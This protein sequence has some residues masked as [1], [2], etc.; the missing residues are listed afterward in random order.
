M[1]TKRESKLLEIELITEYLYLEDKQAVKVV[2]AMMLGSPFISDTIKLSLLDAFLHRP[3]IP[4]PVCTE[5]FLTAFF[6]VAVAFASL[7][8]AF[9]TLPTHVIMKA[10]WRL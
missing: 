2:T 4:P 8:M 7:R 5:L 10:A 3:E 1:C 9:C 6:A